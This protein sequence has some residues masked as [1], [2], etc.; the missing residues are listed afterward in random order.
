MTTPSNIPPSAPASVPIR[1]RALTMPAQIPA[2]GTIAAS[3]M[4]IGWNWPGGGT[5]AS[6]GSPGIAPR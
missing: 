1:T 4:T 6:V 5:A 2:A 3:T